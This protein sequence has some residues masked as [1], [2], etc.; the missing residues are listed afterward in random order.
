MRTLESA[1]KF[2]FTSRDQQPAA[3]TYDPKLPVKSWADPAATGTM[4][5]T[6][7]DGSKIATLTVPPEQAGLNLPGLALFPLY[8]PP[9]TL[10]HRGSGGLVPASFVSTREQAETLMG[11]LNL[12]ATALFDAG[13]VLWPG[14]PV[15]YP[16]PSQDP[17]RVWAFE[18]KTQP[19]V[20][21]GPLLVSE[22]ANGVGA[23]GHWDL[24]E[25]VPTWVSEVPATAP[26]VVGDPVPMALALNPGETVILTGAP[27]AMPWVVSA[28]DA[29]P[30][31]SAAGAGLTAEQDVR[32]K[33]VETMLQAVIKAERITI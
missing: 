3:P 17:R 23:P 4:S 24:S 31:A 20:L 2:Q 26:A 10:A 12:P 19:N 7:W 22:Y 15:I 25:T 33:N 13:P 27:F 28:G 21:V 6:V 1:Y 5:Y 16:D 14:F 9:P 18:F 8:N 29:A 32:L 11:G 30:P